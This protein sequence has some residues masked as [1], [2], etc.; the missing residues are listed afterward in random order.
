MKNISLLLLALFMS[1]ALFAQKKDILLTISNKEITSDEFKYIYSKNNTPDLGIKTPSEYLD[2]FI[3]FKVFVVE[4]ENLKMDTSKQ[5]T[6]ELEGYKDQLAEPF[7]AKSV[8]NEKFLKE[9]YERSKTEIKIDLIHILVNSKATPEQKKKA[10]AKANKILSRLSS[11]ED[12]EKVATETSDNKSVARTKGHLPFLPANQLP[13]ALQNYIFSAKKGQFSQPIDT[14]FGYYII[15]LVD[16]R[17]SQGQVQVAHIMVAAPN[18]LTDEE[19]LQKKE[20]AENIWKE[21]NDGKPFKELAKKSDDKGT[22]QKGGQLPW[23]STGRMVSEFEDAAFALKNKG[24]YTK[25]IH[26]QFGWHIIQL[27]DKKAAESFESASPKLQQEIDRDPIRRE[28][29]TEYVNKELKSKFEFRKFKGAEPLYKVADSSLFSAK[30]SYSY[31]TDL[32][33]K[34]FQVNGKTYTAENFAD[35][36]ISSQ[37]RQQAVPIKNFVNQKYKTFVY[38]TLTQ[39]EKDELINTNTDYQNT[40]R[41]YH[42]GMLL[43]D[44]KKEHIWDKAAEDSTALRKFYDDNKNLFQNNLILSMTVFEYKDEKTA[45]KFM[46]L[47]DKDWEKM[48]DNEIIKKIGKKDDDLKI[49]LSGEYRAKEN[50]IADKVFSVLEENSAFKKKKSLHL[51]ADKLIVRIKNRSIGKDKSFED[52]K[53]IVIA[54]FQNHLEKEKLIEL[55]KKYQIK[56][57]KKQLK[58]LENDL[59]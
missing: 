13:Y 32:S 14:K 1:T 59:K 53:G 52:I 55:K 54:E 3:N 37:R 31:E 36:L 23:F 22:A 8:I 4:A 29:I 41:E 12:F 43:F 39:T 46:S 19:A 48:T 50:L 51:P 45:E 58:K 2:L 26:T 28:K 11:G 20:K 15:R 6:N 33:D 24:D 5:F 9:A 42:D 44:Y 25:P 40:I 56:V 27:I 57:N 17:A 35:Y 49:S 21:L 47:S 10:K 30:W 7:L 38:E 16:K 34:L 18:N